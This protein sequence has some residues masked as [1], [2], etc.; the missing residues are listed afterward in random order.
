[1]THRPS[2]VLF[3]DVN[4]PGIHAIARAKAMGCRVS[5]M[6]GTSYSMYADSDTNRQI[7]LSVDELVRLPVTSDPEGVVACGVELA[8]RHAVD[9]VV[10]L[11]EY[12]MEATAALAVRLGLRSF[13]SP[14]AVRNARRKEIAR[15]LLAQ[16]HLA[17]A[18]YAHVDIAA[19]ALVAAQEIGLP[20]VVKP[21]SGADSILASRCNTLD[22]VAHA[23]QAIVERRGQLPEQMRE[24]M[25]R[26]ILVEEHLKGP[27][28]SA[29]IMI[30]DGVV[31]PYMLSGRVLGRLDETIEIGAAMPADVPI[32]VRDQC[33]EYAQKV[34]GVLGLDNGF[35]HLEMILTERGPVLVEA[36]PRLMGGIMPSVYKVS[37][38]RDILDDVIRVHL[39]LDLDAPPAARRC[40]TSRK[41]MP[42]QS[43]RLPTD[44]TALHEIAAGLDIFDAPHLKPG[45]AIETGA[46]VGRLVASGS[47]AS[48]A[49]Q[50]AD[51]ALA[52]ISS[53][54]DIELIL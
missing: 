25:S 18:A 41:V 27:L 9:A 12:A 4:Y 47:T 38:G 32:E 40:A 20:V 54:L 10:T 14:T 30:R 1:M 8:S 19:Q 39:G 48:E 53:L 50:R 5:L 16:A 52:A 36:N 51:S 34:A 29:E 24:Q 21:S 2:H 31:V 22:E 13:F 15:R 35:A 46:I 3:V 23:A 44:L 33:F 43:V 49:D 6:L 7:L 37:T 11:Q 28:V 45:A 17:S 42:K 26:G